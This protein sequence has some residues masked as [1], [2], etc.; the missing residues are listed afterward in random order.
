MRFST[1]VV[2][3]ATLPFAACSS[4]GGGDTAAGAPVGALPE[5][6]AGEA[7]A[8][9]EA[10]VA[11]HA[12]VDLPRT[13]A[14]EGLSATF[15]DAADNVLYA[16]SDTQPSLTPLLGSVDH[17]R[18][19]PGTPTTLT[20]R[21]GAAWDGEGLTRIDG[22]FLALTVETTPTLERFDAKGVFLASVPLPAI[23]TQQ[24]AGNK[25]IESLASS[26]DG[27]YLFAANEAA[28]VPDGE[29]ASKAAGTRV[30]ILRRELATGVE[31][32]HAYLTEPLGPGSGGDMGVSDV[33]ALSSTDL[34]VLERGFQ[35]DYGS[36]VR[37]FR[38]DLAG[39]ADVSASPA[40]TSSSPVVAKELV[41]DL[42]DLPPS[43]ATH[44]A[45]QPSPLLDNYEALSVGPTLPDGRRL[46]FVTSD[47]NASRTQVARVLV[48]AVRGL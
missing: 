3:V 19:T 33:A 16:L 5:T 29:A 30:R 17:T 42:L 12:V 27:A 20:K 10:R 41:V 36:T 23:Y 38:V 44:P 11:V 28:L 8:A 31:T 22:D 45:T 14:T 40:L 21:P 9:T 47:D 34:L 25:G 18:W 48:L 13:F 43:G 4:A 6:A 15:Y 26:P 35:P 1:L 39:A 32:Q 37:I 2:L 24:R 7:D 46:L